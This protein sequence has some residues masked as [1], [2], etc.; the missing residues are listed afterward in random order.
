MQ[1][2]K[3][4]SALGV[5]ILLAAPQVKGDDK[6]ISVSERSCHSRSIIRNL[7]T[8]TISDDILSVNFYDSSIYSLTVEAVAGD[9][10][11]Q[12]VLPADGATYSYD[13]S[14]LAPGDYCLVLEGPSGVYEGYFYLD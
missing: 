3:V 12:A 10:V 5:L 1:V 7:P 2:K 8:A 14:G 4:L 9:C 11:Y 6:E 13:L